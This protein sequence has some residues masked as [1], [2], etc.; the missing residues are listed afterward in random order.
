MDIQS[1]SV[2]LSQ[3]RLQEQAAVQVQAM[4]LDAMKEQAAA[5]EKLLSSTQAI[6]DPNLGQKINVIA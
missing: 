4:G 2:N 3:A 5:L 1:A 6:T